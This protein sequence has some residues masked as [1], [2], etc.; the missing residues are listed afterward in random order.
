MVCGLSCLVLWLW[1]VKASTRAASDGAS[2]EHSAGRLDNVIFPN[3][4][5]VPR[6][7]GYGPVGHRLRRQP[8]SL[9]GGFPICWRLI[10]HRG[11]TRDLRFRCPPHSLEPGTLRPWLASSLRC[12]TTGMCA[13]PGAPRDVHIPGEPVRPLWS[14]EDAFLAR[15][16]TLRRHRFQ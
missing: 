6:A 13:H 10:F 11:G 7:A 8:P 16:H 2:P 5:V 14:Q 3:G 4:F 12:A 15:Q 1:L 9:V